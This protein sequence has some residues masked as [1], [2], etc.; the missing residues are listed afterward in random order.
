MGNK[1]A[2]ILLL[3]VFWFVGC[4]SNINDASREGLAKVS[5]NAATNTAVQP[6]DL[7]SKVYLLKAFNREG[8]EVSLGSGFLMQG[9]IVTNAHVVADAGWVQVYSDT[10]DHITTAPYAIHVDIENDL[11][12]L[13]FPGNTASG[14][15]RTRSKPLIGTDIWAFGSPMGFQNTVSKGNVSS[16]RTVDGKDLIQI[17]APISSGS[18]GGPVTN[19]EGEVI[20]VV[21]GLY[22]EGQNINFAIPI[23]KL[24]SEISERTAS[25]N[26]PEAA[27][28]QE[29][30][31]LTR[32]QQF[33]LYSLVTAEEVVYGDSFRIPI[34][35]QGQ[36][37]GEGALKVFTFDGYARQE[38][39]IAALG[40]GE[41]VSI[42]LYEGGFSEKEN[43]WSVEDRGGGL[44]TASVIQTTLPAD[45]T[46]FLALMKNEGEVE[47]GEN[48]AMWFG[49]VPRVIALE[50]RW[51]QIGG[52][53]G[54]ELYIDKESL[55]RGKMYSYRNAPIKAS[56]WFYYLY[57][58]E[59]TRYGKKYHSMM[60]Q[61]DLFCD[62]REY[63]IKKT[64]ELSVDDTN[65]SKSYASK[66]SVTPNTNA[67]LM[68]KA[69][70]AK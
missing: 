6:G 34:L 39:E 57:D 61:V 52:E 16:F 51:I 27:E 42:M 50:K 41:P 67:E 19:T 70:C 37:P 14:L 45:G 15:P 23:G 59:V 10:G 47:S 58:K 62:S 68:W 12:V 64:V 25:I 17:T 20:G 1:I 22:S 8:Q 53:G 28:F 3:Q 49:N 4:A 48:V 69:G 65:E 33:M 13:P 43:F 66:E 54:N 40:E 9:A 32:T 2:Y 44:R 60:M 29:K 7:L 38:V 18:S 21:V 26:F 56:A 5:T 31:E 30:Q 36:A 63:Q 35:D 55:Q 11:A 24:P 46:Y